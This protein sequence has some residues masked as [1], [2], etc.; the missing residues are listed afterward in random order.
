M[1]THTV[2]VTRSGN[3]L[4]CD[5][6]ETIAKRGDIIIWSGPDGGPPHTGRFLGRLRVAQKR[7]GFT[8]ADLASSNVDE[9]TL[10]LAIAHWAD[11][12]QV[13]IPMTARAGTYSYMVQID[14]NPGQANAQRIVSDPVVIIDDGSGS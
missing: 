10:P 4:V 2:R 8:K 14:L 12:Q 1:A 5:P 13:H 3:T 11:G 9:A 7:S 6:P